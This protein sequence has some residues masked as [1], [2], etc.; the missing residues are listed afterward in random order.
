MKPLARQLATRLDLASAYQKCPKTGTKM[1]AA[2]AAAAA[3]VV[4][5]HG[6][7]CFELEDG[8]SAFV[9]F[10]APGDSE[11]DDAGSGIQRRMLPPGCA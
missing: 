4:I 8:L 9:V 10:F 11:V 7:R 2:A 5:K 3:K 6:H 1:R